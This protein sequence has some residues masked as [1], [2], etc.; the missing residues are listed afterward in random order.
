VVFWISDYESGQPEFASLSARSAWF[1][2]AHIANVSPQTR[3]TILFNDRMEIPLTAAERSQNRKLGIDWVPYD[4]NL[5]PA[6]TDNYITFCGLSD[7]LE[8][9]LPWDY[10]VLSPKRT[11]T[12]ETLSIA[13][14]LGL[15]HKEG[16]FLT[17]HQ[18]RVR[19]EMVGREETYLAGSARYPCDLHEALIQGRS[20]ARK[21]AE[22]YHKSAAGELFVPRV[23]CVVDPTKCIGCGLCQDLCDCGGIGVEEGNSGGLPRVV[24][25]MVCTGGGTCAAA[26]PYRALILQ[27]N[28]TAQR[29]ARVAALASMLASDEI[30]TIACEW[31]GLPA[32]DLAGKFGLK[33]DPRVHILGV[34]CVGQIDPCVMARAFKEGA[35]NL[36]LIGCLPEECHHSAGIDHAWSRV[37]TIK[38]LL[39]LC[40]FDRRR[41]ALAHAD[42]NQPKEFIRTVESFSQAMTALGPIENSPENQ[43]KLDAIYHLTKY[44]TRVR[45]LLTAGLRRTWE[46]A[47]RGDRQHLLEYD[48]DYSTA[49][50]EEFMQQRLI[51]LLRK[52]QRPLNMNE[53]AGMLKEDPEHVW[54]SLRDMTS[55]NIIEFTHD[56]Q[57]PLYALSN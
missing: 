41:I 55:N 2:A 14:I 53:L 52:M 57:T 51:D 3:V 38:K 47:Y 32:A 37:N 39:T 19:P 4:K 17:G 27:N 24:D 1:M 56:K 49:L 30:L 8:H 35:S 45:H 26:C 29:E 25:P 54:E 42:L 10:L 36:L 48:R 33:Y 22:M 20:A 31:G 23:V 15:V 11:V 43:A 40:G 28:T 34:P 6:P 5:R 12:G 50:M 44:N 13:K 9:E 18:A 21:T 16:R 7:R 46:N